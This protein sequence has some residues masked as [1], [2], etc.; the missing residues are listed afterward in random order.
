[1]KED[2]DT[3]H[4]HATLA[5]IFLLLLSPLTTRQ[6]KLEHFSDEGDFFPKGYRKSLTKSGTHRLLL[7]FAAARLT[8]FPSSLEIPQSNVVDRS[9]STLLQQH[10]LI[11]LPSFDCLALLSARLAA[12]AVEETID[13]RI[14]VAEGGDQS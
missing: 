6:K 7:C 9:S 3:Q 14:H 2:D 12:L 4:R 8:I 1:M 5:G 10:F 11:F 13:G